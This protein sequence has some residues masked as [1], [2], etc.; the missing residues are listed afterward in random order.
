MFNKQFLIYLLMAR[1]F[2]PYHMVFISAGEYLINFFLCFHC[3]ARSYFY[4]NLTGWSVIVGW[5][6][7]LCVVHMSPVFTCCNMTDAWSLMTPVQQTGLWLMKTRWVRVKAPGPSTVFDPLLS[8]N[9]QYKNI[10]VVWTEN[11][12]TL[13]HKNLHKLT[14]FFWNTLQVWNFSP[15]AVMSTTKK[16]INNDDKAG[17]RGCLGRLTH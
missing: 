8:S 15:E 6:T 9:F 14:R 16:S 4:I 11:T 5:V 13:A 7:W 12:E 2:G 17:D 1:S 3:Y 10:C